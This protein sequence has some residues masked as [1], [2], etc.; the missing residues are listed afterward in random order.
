MYQRFN[1]LGSGRQNVLDVTFERG[2]GWGWG[3]SDCLRRL[4]TQ[5]RRERR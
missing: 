2:P 5:G 3:V 4:V 1:G